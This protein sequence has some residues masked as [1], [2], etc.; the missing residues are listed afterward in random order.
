MPGYRNA[1]RYYCLETTAAPQSGWLPVPGFAAMP[2]AP[3]V[4]TV[5]C[6]VPDPAGQAFY[7]L[8]VWL[9]QQP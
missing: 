9:Q 5:T 3:G 1:T 2:A 8:R 7:R 6:E 4:H